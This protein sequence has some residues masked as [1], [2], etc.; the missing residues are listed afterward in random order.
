M[1][2]PAADS[3]GFAVSGT[4]IFDYRYGELLLNI[5][6]CYAATGNIA[7][8]VEYLGK[9]RGRVG[10]PSA[11]NYGIGS[12]ADKNAALEACLYERRIELAYE[13]KRFWDIQRW[14]LYADDAATNDNTN[15]KLGIPII[16]GTNRTGYYWQGKN[17][18]SSDPLTASDRNI[19][20]SYTHLTL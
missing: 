4:D 5:A 9:I 3:I 10:I 19:S 7:K 15:A 13:G 17:F 20:V 14:M 2:N 11:N 6:E 12:L 1:S 18:T 16:N 8:C